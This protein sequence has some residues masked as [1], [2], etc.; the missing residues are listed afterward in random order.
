MATRPSVLVFDVNETLLALESMAPLFTRVFG[1][2]MALRQW[3]NQLVLYSMTVTLSGCYTDFFTLSKSVLQMLA[4]IHEVSLTGDDREAIA[5]GM[6]TMP[7]HPDVEEGLKALADQGFRLVTLT[8]SPVRGDAPSPIDN[9]GLGDFFERQFTVNTLRA[10]KPAT[11][12]Y[13]NV[14]DELSLAPSECMMVAAHAWDIIGAQSA[15]Y[16]G[17]L[18]TRPG[19]AALRVDGVPA[20]TL[21]ARDIRDLAQQLADRT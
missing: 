15:G 20:P 9:A 1:D 14:A 3:F 12:L 4:D 21:V 16:T 19:N 7:A 13:T 17:S 2:P 8:N 5:Q 6:R 10:F 11:A 18:I